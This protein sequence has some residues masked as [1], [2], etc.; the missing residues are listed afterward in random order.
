MAMTVAGTI[1]STGTITKMHTNE[2]KPSRR[3][4][5]GHRVG[6]TRPYMVYLR[7][8]Q[9]SKL[10]GSDWICGGVIIHERYVLTSAA[11]IEEAKHFFV[12]SGTHRWIPY[13]ETKNECIVN[14]A[15]KAVWKCVPKSYVYDGDDFDNMR[16][17]VGDIA[18]VKVEDE[19]NFEKRVRGCD[20]VPKKIDFNNHTEDLEEERGWGSVAGWGTTEAF[21]VI[22][23]EED[24][25]KSK[26]RNRNESVELM[27]SDVQLISIKNCKKR[28]DPRYHYI[29]DE[30][31]V[32]TKDV[33]EEPASSLCE[34]REVNCKELGSSETD[35][36]DYGDDDPNQKEPKEEQKKI[37]RMII[38]PRQLQVHT[39]GHYYDTRR[40]NVAPSGGFCQNDHG[41]P[42]IVGQGKT[43]VVV[44]VM[45]ACLT[46]DVTKKCYGP[47]LFTSV[48]RYK[49]M[50]SCAIDKELGATCRMLLRTSSKTPIAE[51]FFDWS[52]H[53]EFLRVGPEANTIEERTTQNKTRAPSTTKA[54]AGPNNVTRT[55]KTHTK[56]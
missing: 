14:G 55:T 38:D 21:E 33:T 36:Y 54:F 46:K 50:I 27:E 43:A 51:T 56:H 49:N 19:F 20:F 22:L 29:I 23:D 30:H 41:G 39:A 47:F 6:D 42:L 4:L 8:A 48:F 9:G 15:K 25:V 10:M 24:K 32:C 5:K 17:M 7:A 53:K 1:N 37:R 40:K 45:S 28:W 12:V 2:T 13:T 16:W 35:D 44:G 26:L 34:E 31:M 3:I 52:Q 11:C 18:V